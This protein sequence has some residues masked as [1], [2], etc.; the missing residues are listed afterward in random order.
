LG[1]L[2]S[3]FGD[4][5]HPKVGNRVYESVRMKRLYTQTAKNGLKPFRITVVGCNDPVIVTNV[6]PSFF[7]VAVKPGTSIRI[8]NKSA[9][10]VTD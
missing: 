5:I 9:V 4:A 10:S 1:V 2:F 3:G 6:T 8:L 7:E